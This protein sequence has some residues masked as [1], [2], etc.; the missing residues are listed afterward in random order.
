[1]RQLAVGDVEGRAHQAHG[2]AAEVGDNL[3]ATADHPHGPIGPHD[4]VLK[5]ER[6]TG[7]EGVPAGFR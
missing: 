5:V 2:F 1:M 4:P 6:L 3:T 7:L